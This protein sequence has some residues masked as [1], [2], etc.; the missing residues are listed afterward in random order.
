MIAHHLLTADL[1]RLL[2]LE[3]TLNSQLKVGENTKAIVK[4]KNPPNSR[5]KEWLKKGF[6][7]DRSENI[8]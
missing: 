8:I 5:F 7:A 3:P 4:K 2:L 6:R 1:C